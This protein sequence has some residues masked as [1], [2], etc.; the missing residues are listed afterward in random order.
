MA[1]DWFRR[2]FTKPTSDPSDQETSTPAEAPTPADPADSSEIDY[3]A[4]AKAAYANIKARQGEEE[5]TPPPS[6]PATDQTTDQPTDQL[7]QTDQPTD[8]PDH[9]EPQ[10]PEAEIPEDSAA[11]SSEPTPSPAPSHPTAFFD[12][13]PKA[14]RTSSELS[15]TATP[16]A[17]SE[18]FWPTATSHRRQR[19]AQK[20][21]QTEE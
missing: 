15:K 2:R 17:T 14:T 18:T 7:E 3:L 10:P 19:K 11:E 8:H 4:F 5:P 1:F 20:K 9:P 13:A 16:D 21:A 12:L 6:D